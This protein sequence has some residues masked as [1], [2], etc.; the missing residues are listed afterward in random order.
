MKGSPLTRWTAALLMLLLVP[1]SPAKPPAKAKKEKEKDEPPASLLFVNAVGDMGLAFFVIDGADSNP[2]GFQFGRA[3]G[4]VQFPAGKRGLLVE[5]QPLGTV[6]LTRE[7]RPA[8]RQAFIAHNLIESQADRGRPPR[9]TIGVLTLPCERSG[10]KLPAGRRLVV[11][12]NATLQDS[13]T[14]SVGGEKA[15]VE[16]LKPLEL[17]VASGTGFAPV[18]TD[19][20]E[21]EPLT[22]LNLE[23]PVVTYVIVHETP[24]GALQAVTFAEPLPPVEEEDVEK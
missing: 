8:S 1:L 12:V 16:R 9:P 18:E 17:Q 19:P 11:V 22:T 23:E 3:T 2:A 14:L 24:M 4:W 7:L 5:H 10:K 13:L 20:A 21:G 15:A 6:D